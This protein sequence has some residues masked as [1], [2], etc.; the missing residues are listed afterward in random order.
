MRA[1]DYSNIVSTEK[2]KELDYN[3]ECTKIKLKKFTGECILSDK[4]KIKCIILAENPLASGFLQY[5]PGG[6]T[7]AV[8]SAYLNLATFSG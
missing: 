8:P 3:I 7:S 1:N 5:L 2:M 6:L 4:E